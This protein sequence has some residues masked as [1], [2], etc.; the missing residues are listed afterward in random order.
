MRNFGDLMMEAME[1]QEPPMSEE[2]YLRV[3]WK[4]SLPWQQDG[5]TTDKRSIWKAQLPSGGI[6]YRYGDALNAM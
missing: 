1:L 5:K 3:K 4:S 6:V 2:G